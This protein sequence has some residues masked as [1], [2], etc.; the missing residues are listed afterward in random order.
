MTMA[1]E[2]FLSDIGIDEN[3]PDKTADNPAI[4]EQTTHHPLFGCK[5]NCNEMKT[6][7]NSRIGAQEQSCIPIQQTYVITIHRSHHT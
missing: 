3:E 1:P 4:P 5:S 7:E 6:V 2:G